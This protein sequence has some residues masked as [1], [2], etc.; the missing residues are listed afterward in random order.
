MLAARDTSARVVGS[1]DEL[2]DDD[3][4]D[5]VC[6]FEV[7]EHIEDDA[8]ALAR[9]TGLLADG[10]TL[11]LSV[12]ADPDRF[13][14]AD[15]AVGHLRRYRATDLVELAARAG[16]VDVEVRHYGAGLGDLL[17]H[18]RNVLLGRRTR[19]AESSGTD[20]DVEERTARSGTVLQP[21]AGASLLTQLLTAPGRRWQRT[22]PNT[23]PGLLLVGRRVG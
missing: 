13:A 14:A 9:W 1:T 23:G 17:E 4:F 6:A 5:L 20:L 7:L 10:G 2:G 3:R 11:V 12:P 8:G 15:T 21:P 22:R 18:G 16:L 19:S